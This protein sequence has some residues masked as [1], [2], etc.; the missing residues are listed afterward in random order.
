MYRS[1][2]GRL[3]LTILT[4]ILA[5]GLSSSALADPILPGYDLFRT[6]PGTAVV[7]VFGGIPLQGV[8]IPGLGNTDT[9][10]QRLQGITVFPDTIQ[11]EIIALSLTSI[12]PIN[13]SGTFFDV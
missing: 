3:P 9:I 7:P 6:P 1:M 5:S 13:I 12:T 8:P 4:L 11:T 2:G 10:V